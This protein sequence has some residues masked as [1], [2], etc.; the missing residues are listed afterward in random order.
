VENNE[1]CLFL[2]INIKKISLNGV[3]VLKGKSQKIRDRIVSGIP[4]QVLISS[5]APSK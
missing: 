2:M 4:R 1:K 5:T 3:Y